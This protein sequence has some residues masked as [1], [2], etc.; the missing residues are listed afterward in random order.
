MDRRALLRL[1]GAALAGGVLDACAPRRARAPLA[2]WPPRQWPPVHVS[3][4]RIIRQVAGLRP[5]RPSGFVIRAEALGSKTVVHNYGH[6]GGGVTLSWGTAHLAVEEAARTEARRFAVL[7]CGAVGL[8]TARLLQRRGFEVTIYARDL[9]PRTTS[10]I[11]G[12]QWSP[13]SVAD[14]N[15]RTTAFDEQ[16]VRAARL[17]YRYFQDLLGAGYGVRWIENY[18][19]GDE[20][21]RPSWERDLI[22]DLFPATAEL[23]PGRH[24]FPTRYARRVLTMFVEPHVYL[25]ALQRD[26][27]LQGGKLVVRELRSATEIGELTEPVVMNCTGLGARTLFGD[28]ELQPVKGQLTVLLPQPE[29]DYAVIAPR[30]LYMFP[31]SDGI[32]LGGTFERGVESLE[33][34]PQQAERILAGHAQLFGSLLQDRLGR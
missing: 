2:P 1:G 25:A 3:A 24:P 26:F 16:F 19:L 8:A 21:P 12:A 15:R 7:G 11:A 6:G 22:A 4:D 27:L 10:N 29:V 32:V 13:V 17:S 28:A 30:S 20:P 23:G 14:S 18:F 9:P 31:R 34:D 5:Y 33:P